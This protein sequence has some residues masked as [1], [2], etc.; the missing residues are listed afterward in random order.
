MAS[1]YLPIIGKALR[2]LSLKPVG[3]LAS[4][5]SIRLNISSG[6]LVVAPNLL[7][8][9]YRWQCSDFRVSSLAEDLRSYFAKG[10]VYDVIIGHSLGGI[11]AL[12]LL[13]YLPPTK[14]TS[15]ILVD[16]ALE[17]SQEVMAIKG[18]FFTGEVVSP[19]TVEA[20]M[21]EHPL[22]TRQ[23][24]TV[25]ALGTRMCMARTVEKIFKASPGF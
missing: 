9:G 25:R 1:P 5:A 22:W 15:V 6:F 2:K 19:R 4:G 16:P 24:A 8:H 13:P 20:Y 23:D 17:Q 3:L 21:A 14:A 18:Q 12:S 11:T 7:G 10:V